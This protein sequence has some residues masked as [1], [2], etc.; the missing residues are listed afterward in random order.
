MEGRQVMPTS[1]LR[2]VMGHLASSNTLGAAGSTPTPLDP[3]YRHASL[4]KAEDPFY[5][6][7]LLVLQSKDLEAAEALLRQP[8]DRLAHAV[9]PS[10]MHWPAD[11]LPPALWSSAD[12]ARLC[13]RQRREP[14]F[15]D[16]KLEAALDLDAL[17]RDGVCVLADVMTP[18]AQ[19][20]WAAGLERCQ[21][22]SVCLCVFV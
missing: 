13:E 18:Q 14:L 2:R 20:Q 15:D 17:A 19:R 5:C 8:T 16:A 1:R 21:V 9:T 6:Q 7:E 4:Y 22:L 3:S 10:C 12:W 11:P